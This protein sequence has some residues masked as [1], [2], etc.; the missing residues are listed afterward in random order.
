MFTYSKHEHKKI[1]LYYMHCLQCF[2]SNDDLEKHRE[3]CI[4][5]NGVQAIELPKIYI[6]KHGKERIPSVY[7][8]NHHKQ[9]PLPFVFYADFESITEKITTCQPCN[10]KSYTQTY[11]RHAACSFGHKVVCHYDKKYSKPVV[12]CR[13]P[14]AV[15]KFLVSMLLEV[16]ELQKVIRENFNKPLNLTKEEEE[17]FQRS[18]HCWICSKKYKEDQKP[19]RDHCHITG[20]YRGSAHDSCNL[21]LKISAEKIKIPVIFH[22]LKGYDSHLIMQDIGQI[23]KDENK[24]IANAIGAF[25]TGPKSNDENF[26]PKLD[27]KVIAQNTEKYMAFYLGKNLVFLDSFQFMS[28]SLEK[29]TN[30]LPIDKVP[31]TD[32]GFGERA[33]L[34]KKK[35][36]YP[37]D[38]RI[39]SVSLK[40]RNY[41]VKKIFITY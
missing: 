21:K 37:Y 33:S 22:N 38:Y 9:L 35:G 3:N 41:H 5:I 31:Y 10:Q 6:D 11:Q 19:V 26:T 24:R 15:Y 12:I 17:E 18:T 28:C 23:I 2:Y 16:N 8:K 14:D 39:V 25:G 1:F 20:K 4:A 40:E 30:N 34:L 7:F 36:F 27:L 32:I 13:G 29:L